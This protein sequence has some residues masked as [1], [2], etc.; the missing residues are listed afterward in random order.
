M[1][2][3]TV[4]NSEL[5]RISHYGFRAFATVQMTSSLFRDVT[6]RTS[7]FSYRRFETTYR[8]QPSEVKHSRI[9]CAA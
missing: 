7:V 5:V 6:Q 1:K 9:D 3:E 2:K 8:V 4:L